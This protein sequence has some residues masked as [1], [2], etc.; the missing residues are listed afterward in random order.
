MAA[1]CTCGRLGINQYIQIDW[2]SWHYCASL[3]CAHNG[4]DDVLASVLSRAGVGRSNMEMA[5]PVHP[6]SA[7]PTDVFMGCCK[8]PKGDDTPTWGAIATDRQRSQRPVAAVEPAAGSA[9]NGLVSVADGESLNTVLDLVIDKAPEAEVE[10]ASITPPPKG[11]C[12]IPKALEPYAIV[13]SSYL[14]FTVSIFPISIC[15]PDP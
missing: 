7:P 8:A 15:V 10:E 11:C 9:S 3:A 12:G 2:A 5:D 13:N 4:V 14:L 6:T 1:K